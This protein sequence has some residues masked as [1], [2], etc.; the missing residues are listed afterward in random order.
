MK[1]SQLI[2][3]FGLTEEEVERIVSKVESGDL[4]DF[5]P[6][7]TMKGRPME[8]DPMETISFKIPRSRVK[9]VNRMAKEAGISRS[10]FVRRA[11]DN[12]LIALA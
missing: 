2:A 7:K 4:S 5:D 1:D 3:E 8:Q 12:E 6:S 10:E 11:I 9:A